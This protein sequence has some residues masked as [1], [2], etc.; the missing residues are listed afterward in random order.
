M[1][2]SAA[3]RPSRRAPPAAETA[4]GLR[5]WVWAVA[6]VALLAGEAFALLLLLA[7]PAFRVRH[8]DLTGNQ[9]LAAADVRAALQLEGTRNIFFLSHA[10][11]EA[12][13]RRLP[14][15][16]SAQ[17]E[18][19]LPDRL[20]VAV[21]EWT[22]VAILQVGERSFY[23]SERGIVLGPA[24]EPGRL[25]VLDRRGLAAIAAGDTVMPPE[26]LSLLIPLNDGFFSAFRLRAVSF[27]LDQRQQLSLNTDRGWPI[28]FGQMATPEDR[29][30][31]EPKLAA[32]KALATKVD[33]TSAPVQ[34]VNLMNPREPV[35]QPRR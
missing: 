23:V 24:A 29:A 30:T 21:T 19:A 4:A 1:T 31:L 16:R 20:R 35:W 7:Q 10:S 3:P 22:P 28:I 12:R 33:L 6:Q 8:V 27:S 17:V 15:V 5:A 34:Y 14:W 2:V 11:L 9:H 18:L 13:L 26:L 32:L 25:P